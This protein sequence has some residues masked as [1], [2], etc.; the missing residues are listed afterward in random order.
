MI[1]DKTAIDILKDRYGVFDI[2]SHYDPTCVYGAEN[3]VMGAMDF[4]GEIKMHLARSG[5]E[6]LLR[7]LFTVEKT[8]VDTRD[9]FSITPMEIQSDGKV[10]YVAKYPMDKYPLDVISAYG[11]KLRE[12]LEAEGCKVILMPKIMDVSILTVEQLTQMRDNLTELIQ[13]LSYDNIIGF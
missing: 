11:K 6:R 13:N 12:A 5:F 10:V 3:R 8:V 2:E 1:I 7:D 9:I 4:D